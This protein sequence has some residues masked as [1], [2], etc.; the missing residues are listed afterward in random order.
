ML[1][2]MDDTVLLATSREAMSIKLQLLYDSAQELDMIMHPDKSKYIVVNSTD[3]QPFH[4]GDIIVSHM[5]EY[6]YLGVNI[7]DNTIA[8]QVEKSVKL[9]KNIA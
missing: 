3:K 4:V 6:I 1:L 7:S 8:K 9:N 2:L 5:I